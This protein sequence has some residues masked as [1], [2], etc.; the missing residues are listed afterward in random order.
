LKRDGVIAATL[1]VIGVLIGTSFVGSMRQ[2]GRL[3]D[4]TGLEQQLFGA[5]VMNVCGRG[6]VT[7]LLPMA[8]AVD[9]P[10][11]QRPLVEFLTQRREAVV[12]AEIP[13]DIPTAAIGGMQSASPYLL[14][15]VEIPWRIGGPTWPAFDRLLGVLF[16]ASIVLAYAFCRVA[17]GPLA[18]AFVAGAYMLSPLHLGNLG[19]VRD[20]SKTPFFIATLVIALL[21]VVRPRRPLSAIALSAAGGALAGAGL[22]LRT[23]IALNLVFVLLAA[24][25]FL[26]GSIRG[27]WHVRA[28]SAC[29]ALVA[30]GAT[31]APVLKSPSSSSNLWH[32]AI[33]GYARISD[34]ALGV[35]PGPYE[36]GYFYD[37][38]YV[39]S[40]VDAYHE[41]TTA[42]T[43]PISV[44]M[45]E[46]TVASR[47]YYRSLLTT[48]PAD[49]LLRAEAALIRILGLPYAPVAIPSDVL[50]AIATAAIR[51]RTRLLAVLSPLAI[52]L[53]VFVIAVV[54]T[55]SVRLAAAITVTVV[56]LGMY[57]SLQ[58]QV[59]HYFHLELVPLAIFGFVLGLPRSRLRLSYAAARRVLLVVAMLAAA[60]MT[61]LLALRAYQQRTATRLLD[62]YERAPIV[63]AA[64]EP[65]PADNGSVRLVRA[66]AVLPPDDGRR[67]M[68]SEQI[69]VE[70]R[71][72]GCKPA[73]L[74]ITFKYAGPF[75]YSR[76]VSVPIDRLT[77]SRVFFTV[78]ATGARSLPP[79]HFVF[80]GIEVPATDTSCVAR[81]GRFAEPDGFPLLIPAV[82]PSD[83]RGLPLHQTLRMLERPAI[84]NVDRVRE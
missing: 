78:Y 32:W 77:S 8:V 81:I 60:F 61:P 3:G 48:F 42:A 23:D 46:Y 4:V 58:F 82:L 63:E 71:G 43:H 79:H 34:E 21:L 80:E 49:A 62:S 73:T 27:T 36:T 10:P 74:P 56:L 12:C 30:F 53:F 69:M 54:G 57:P 75:D 25:V 11:T 35:D 6:V 1:F 52:P 24:V 39:A 70:T 17:S 28:A 26:P 9:T 68:R 38:S 15:V 50:P 2:M 37:D 20:Y 7:P 64:L 5:A 76:T 65:S 22:G 51:V 16:A 47:A 55:E 83:W 84:P 59:R 44:D 19:N 14:R 72:D 67:F 40:I 29:V 33:L 45:P 18:S 13:R 41:R 31:A 66:A